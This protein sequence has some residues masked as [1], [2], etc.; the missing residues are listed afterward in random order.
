[1]C[2]SMAFDFHKLN[3][4]IRLETILIHSPLHCPGDKGRWF[5]CGGSQGDSMILK[6]IDGSEKPGQSKQRVKSI[7]VM[8]SPLHQAW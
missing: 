4:C 2:F 8:V 6:Q 3:F 5:R 1:M 7:H